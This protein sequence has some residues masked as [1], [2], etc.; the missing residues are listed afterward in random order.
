M[1]FFAVA[2]S[3]CCIAMC[4]WIA[5]PPFVSACSVSR[6]GR[7]EQLVLAAEQQMQDDIILLPMPNL[8]PLDPSIVRTTIGRTA[9]FSCNTPTTEAEK[10]A[11]QIIWRHQNVTVY[12]D[13]TV[14]ASTTFNYSRHELN[15]S[16]YL[17]IHNVTT[18][19][20]GSVRCF[21][22]H[23]EEVYLVKH[24][25]LQ[26]R[27]RAEDVFVGRLRNVST[28]YFQA[29][30]TC[31]AY[32]DCS[33]LHG[34][35]YFIWKFDGK[36]AIMSKQLR[37]YLKQLFDSKSYPY[38]VSEFES[39]GRCSTFAE[40]ARGAPCNSTFTVFMKRDM[41]LSPT[42]VECWAQPDRNINEWYVQK[43]YVSFI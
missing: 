17:S 31:T 36:F 2:F 41:K 19:A 42:L 23:E 7:T 29:S 37:H 10:F 16:H 11:Q 26:T 38:G 9:V 1:T 40:E 27:P 14:P 6:V 5:T 20:A 18:L 22:Y 33:C 39:K 3:N 13:H 24:F 32:V 35:P 12:A 43:T 4:L 28:P 21:Q 30:L 25:K 8:P 15:G 34:G